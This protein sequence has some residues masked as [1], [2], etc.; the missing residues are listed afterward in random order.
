MV[1][2]EYFR[3]QQSYLPVYDKAG[4]GVAGEGSYV[5]TP[6]AR[7]EVSRGSFGMLKWQGKRIIAD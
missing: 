2:Y 3:F 6:R 7:N 4:V 5:S 1:A